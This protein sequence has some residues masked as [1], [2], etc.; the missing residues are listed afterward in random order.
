[1]YSRPLR[2]CCDCKACGREKEET[3]PDKALVRGGRRLAAGDALKCPN[4][5]YFTPDM[6]RVAVKNSRVDPFFTS[7]SLPSMHGLSLGSSSLLNL[8]DMPRIACCGAGVTDCY[9]EYID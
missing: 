4:S 5:R 2:Y 1:M 9:T 6:S 8:A 3:I 7:L